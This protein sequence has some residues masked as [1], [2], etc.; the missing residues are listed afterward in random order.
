MLTLTRQLLALN[1][2]IQ[3]LHLEAEQL[4]AGDEACNNQAFIKL[5]K[6][7]HQQSQSIMALVDDMTEY[8]FVTNTEITNLDF[9]IASKRLFS[10]YTRLL[11]FVIDYYVARRKAMAILENEFSSFADKQLD[12]L[13]TKAIK[14]KSQ[15]KTVSQALG[16]EEYQNFLSQHGLPE[17]EWGWMKLG[18]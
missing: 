11:E 1:M 10:I 14:A 12:L 17:H 4:E 15:F 13:Q 6:Q 18:L 16:K 8:E 2:L 7:C 9:E 5:L 3:D